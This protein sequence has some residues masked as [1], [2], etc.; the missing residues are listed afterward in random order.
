MKQILTLFAIGAALAACAAKSAQKAVA[1]SAPKPAAKSAPAGTMALDGKALD[2]LNGETITVLG[3]DNVPHIVRLFGIDALPKTEPWGAKAKT[4]LNDLVARQN[5]RV[6]W[7]RRNE[8]GYPWSTVVLGRQ[9]LSLAMLSAGLAWRCTK[10]ELPPA[11]AKAEAA[12][13]AARRGIWSQKDLEL[14]DEAAHHP[15]PAVDAVTTATP[16]SRGNKRK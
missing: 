2:A 13:K 10:V 9:N 8:V 7:D 15:E 3:G 4:F 11:Y 14:P 1:K 12:A 5:V 16:K 6:T